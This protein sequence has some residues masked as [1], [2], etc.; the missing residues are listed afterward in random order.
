MDKLSKLQAKALTSY[1]L[2]DALKNDDT[3]YFQKSY[4]SEN[5]RIKRGS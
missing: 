3:G 4:F 5:Q 2:K 1:N